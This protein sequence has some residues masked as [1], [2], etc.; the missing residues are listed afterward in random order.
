MLEGDNNSAFDLFAK[1]CDIL[2][3]C[4]SLARD[5]S[6]A[7]VDETNLY[8]I[9][10][11]RQLCGLERSAREILDVRRYLL[12]DCVFHPHQ[13][14]FTEY[15]SELVRAAISNAGVF[16]VV[17]DFD[18]WK[19]VC[20]P[21]VDSCIEGFCRLYGD[22]VGKRRRLSYEHYSECY[23]ANRLSRAEQGSRT[24]SVVRSSSSLSRRIS[25]RE[26]S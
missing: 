15:A 14:H 24:S 1:L 16:F 5:E 22:F 18:V 9:E 25:F 10:K 13:S 2:E 8:V 26:G 12:D 6:I 4:G 23:R 7:A 20:D 19:D 21:G 3:R 11:R 17:S